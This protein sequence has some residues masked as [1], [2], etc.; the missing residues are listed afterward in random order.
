MNTTDLDTLPDV[1][2]VTISRIERGVFAGI[3]RQRERA[4]A[5]RG[6]VWLGVAAAAAVVVVAAVISPAVLSGIAGGAASEEAGSAVAPATDAGGFEIGPDG[7]GA[8]DMITGSTA[9]GR[10]ESEAVAGAAESG[11]RE[12]IA[13][14]SLTL[15][16]DDVAEAASGVA[17]EAESRGGY[18]ESMSVGAD[19]VISPEMQ[20]M[21]GGVIT[22][23]TRPMLREGAWVQIRVPADQLTDT[24]SALGGLGEVT[25]SSVS[26]QDVT[27]QAVDLRARI[28]AAEASVARLSDLMTQSGSVADLIAAESA[29]SERQATLESYRQQL[30][31]LEGQVALSSL[32]VQL[33]A[34]RGEPVAA[35][36]A[37]FG[38]GLAAGW[39]GLVAT[40]NGVV[41]ALG[42]L[43]PWL[44]VLGA[45]AVLAWW[46][47]RA[48]R[49]RRARRA[50]TV[51]ED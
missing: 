2:D 48:L 29:L 41:V 7:A 40:L 11:E 46:I 42:F 21:Q 3:H 39:N 51:L 8:P 18:V 10:T 26:R 4:R 50:A 32:T 13:S 27:D 23:T 22:D 14:G 34:A 20:G 25:S 24:M 15:T 33:D 49:R 47:T 6:R 30:D 17:S 31:V 35:D 5:R 12:L 9:D 38:D 1:S 28:T 36:P 43:L 44:V 45:A 37:G 19:G 16:V